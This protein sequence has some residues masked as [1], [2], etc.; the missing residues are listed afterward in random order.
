V[1]DEVLLRLLTETISL[2]DEMPPY[3]D[4]GPLVGSYN[5]VLRGAK[6]NHTG[7]AFL[8]GMETVERLDN[9]YQL[10]ILFTQLQIVLEALREAPQ[11]QAK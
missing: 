3:E 5:A 8:Q 10:Q 1:N 11:P 2:L 4:A 7:V 9:K 6:A